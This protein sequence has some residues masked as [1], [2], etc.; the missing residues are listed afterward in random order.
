MAITAAK[1]GIIKFDLQFSPGDALSADEIAD[2]NRYRMIMHALEL[3]GQDPRRYAGY[4]FG[5]ISVRIAPFD[6]P[7]H[8]RRFAI[9]GTQTGSLADL[10]PEHYAIVEECEPEHNRIVATGPWKPSSES[11]THG[12]VYDLDPEVYCVIHVHS[13]EIWNAAK[14]L[15]LPTTNASVPYGCPEMAAEVVRLYAETDLPE[16]RIF[17]M[18]G[19]EDGIVAFGPTSDSAA[20]TLLT[21]LRQAS[22]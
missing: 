19:H 16:R 5:N 20:R 21:A 13:P 4:G 18:G 10:G 15:Q 2:V 22:K 17:S 3:I 11:L 12:V 9:T 6:T 1:D 8:H 7:V 14:R